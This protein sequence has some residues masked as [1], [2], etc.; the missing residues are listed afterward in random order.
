[1]GFVVVELRVSAESLERGWSQF[2]H[3]ALQYWSPLD[4]ILMALCEATIDYPVAPG[5]KLLQVDLVDK[6]ANGFPFRSL[7]E[8][9]TAVDLRHQ[10]KL[11]FYCICN[12]EQ[13]LQRAFVPAFIEIESPFGDEELLWKGTAVEK[14]R[15]RREAVPAVDDD[16][17]TSEAEDDSQRGS[18]PDLEQDGHGDDEDVDEDAYV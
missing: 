18:G 9:I 11:L 7:A 13:M 6:D 16:N 15:K 2:Y 5:N 4:A 12:S 3:V 17:A 10:I 1:M 14:Q 8:V